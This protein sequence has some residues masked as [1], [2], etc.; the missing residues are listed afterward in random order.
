MNIHLNISPELVERIAVALES[1]EQHL[2]ALIPTVKGNAQ[3]EPYGS[4]FLGRVT[5]SSAREQEQADYFE[6]IGHGEDYKR[7]IE[8]QAAVQAQVTAS[9]RSAASSSTADID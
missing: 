4:D 8:E 2:S 3:N 6:S 9:L 7:W 1:I 5:N